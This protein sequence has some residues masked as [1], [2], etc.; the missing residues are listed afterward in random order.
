MEY[1]ES[2]DKE[3]ILEAIGTFAESV[4]KRFEAVDRRFEMIESTMATKEDLKRFA[5]KDDLKNFATKEDF[6]NIMNT[7][8][9]LV[10]HAKKYDQEFLMMARGFRRLSDDVD[11]IKPLVGLA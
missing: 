8:D 6:A 9:W 4:D 7:L 5:T 1:M 11:K 10:G 3:E 2:G